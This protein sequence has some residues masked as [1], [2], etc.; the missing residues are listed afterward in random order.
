[1]LP[2][3]QQTWC[4]PS[5][6]AQLPGLSPSASPGLFHSQP[7]GN[8]GSP[9]PAPSLQQ[10]SLI[11]LITRQFS[12]R[13][14]LNQCK[15]IWLTWSHTRTLFFWPASP[16]K[17]RKKEKKTKKQKPNTNKITNSH[18][19]L[20]LLTNQGNP[21]I[22]TLWIFHLDHICCAESFLLPKQDFRV[23]VINIKS[24]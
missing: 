17:K 24:E 3:K 19:G 18:D 6:L 21:I 5:L 20:C 15:A 10:W 14:T 23:T 12:E 11:S 13:S 2:Q 7:Q 1:M 22:C 4:H 8:Q 16:P 9:G